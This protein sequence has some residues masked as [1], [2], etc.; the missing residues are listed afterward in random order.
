VGEKANVLSGLTEETMKTESIEQSLHAHLAQWGLRRFTRDEAYFKWQ[1]QVLSPQQLTGLRDHAE[2]KRQGSSVDEKAFYDLT[3]HPDILPV[4]YSQRYDYYLAIG[5]VVAARIAEA[6]TILDFGCGPGILTTFY[7]RRFPHAHVVGLDR[8][9]ASIAAAQ[10]KAQEF[11]LQ[12]VRFECVDVE[13][14]PLGGTYNCV[15]ATHALVQ[16]ELDPGLPSQSWRTFERARDQLQQ[17]EFE[18]RTGTGVRLDR[19]IAVMPPGGRMIVFEKTRQLARR[20]PLQRAFSARDLQLS[21]PPALIRYPLVEEV[22]DDGPFYVL[23]KG[24]GSGLAWDEQPEPDDGLP[25]DRTALRPIAPDGPLY[26]NHCP[27]AQQVWERLIDRQVTRE[28]TNQEPDGRQLHVELGTAEGLAYLYCANTF[29]QRQLALIEPSR[30]FI[31]DAYYQE[32]L[33]G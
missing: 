7:A 21:E 31:L 20:V 4:L 18:C 24:Q 13:A 12:N 30:A 11:D 8:S 23:R 3:A 32:I 22:S 15:V 25:F 6:Q 1:E 2:Q 29:D 17:S 27:S 16:S 33:A 10:Q 28:T 26:D 19:L 5:P 14:G 9:S